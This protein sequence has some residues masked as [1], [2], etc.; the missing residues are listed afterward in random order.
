[1]H[2]AIAILDSGVGGLTVVKE[3]MRQLP[4]EKIIY[5][6]DTARAPYGPRTPEQVRLF[7]EQ[8]VDFLIQFNPKMVVIACNTATAAA[9]DFI[10]EKLTIPVIGV[11]HPGARAAISATKTGRVGVIGTIGT[12]QS[13]AYT[14]ALKELSPYIEVVSEACPELVPLVEQGEFETEHTREIVRSSLAGIKQYDMDCLILGCTHYP[15]LRKAIREV[16][17]PGVKLISSADETAREISTVLYQ[18]G[19]LARGAEAP[20]HQFFCSGDERIFRQIAKE[21]LGEEI[22]LTPIVWH[23]GRMAEDVG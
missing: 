18:K 22:Q 20:V 14:V 23:V 9:L 7:T 17:G 12:I 4:R 3:V 19:Q 10:S 15:F 6:G 1:M 11:I 8:I 2:Q 16:M 13:G 21:W 5:F